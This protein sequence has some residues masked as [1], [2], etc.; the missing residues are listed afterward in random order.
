MAVDGALSRERFCE[1]ILGKFMEEGPLDEMLMGASMAL[2]G[3]DEE[4]ATKLKTDTLEVLK[5][6][7]KPISDMAFDFFDK[8]KD[9]NITK[10]EFTVAAEALDNNPMAAG[11]AMFK[12]LDGNGN[13]KVEISEAAEFAVGLLRIAQTIADAMIDIGGEFA[14]GPAVAMVVQ[15]M[16]GTMDADQDGMITLEEA[17][18]VADGPLQ[19]MSEGVGQMM[20][21]PEEAL[22]PQAV[23]VRNYVKMCQDE[24]IPKV[25]ESLAGSYPLDK[26]TFV[27]KSM[28]NMNDMMSN[29][30]MTK[31]LDLN[32]EV[33]NMPPPLKELLVS[34]LT[35][36]MDDAKEAF[37][38]IAAAQFEL[39]AKDGKM[40][41]EQAD[42][43][44]TIL[45]PVGA[46]Q[47]FD[48]VWNLLDADSD[49]KITEAEA[50]EFANK[51]FDAFITSAHAIT[52]FYGAMLEKLGVAVITKLIEAKS[53]D[54]LTLEQ[55]MEMAQ[56]GPEMAMMTIMG[57][58]PQ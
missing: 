7:V 10:E 3:L 36:A 56:Q 44:I 29:D 6:S 4:K 11:E 28:E 49:G 50:T 52:A 47:K 53:S 9:G 37:G 12:I 30:F 20:D 5:N 18:A 2:P 14:R 35:D 22:P 43:C 21:A 46:S 45:L 41:E 8:N 23:A 42:A 57:G 26:D 34:A 48:Q 25:K 58:P 31:S 1:F 32:P 51:V 55:A 39:F 27:A 24:I 54:G 13:G 40:T 33:Q 38:A 16:F 17:H 15:T 19:M